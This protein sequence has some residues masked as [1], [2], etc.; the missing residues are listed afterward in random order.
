MVEMKKSDWWLPVVLLKDPS[1]KPDNYGDDT[2]LPILKSF[3]N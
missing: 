1:I 2:A 3:S